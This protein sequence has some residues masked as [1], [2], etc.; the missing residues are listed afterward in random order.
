MNDSTSPPAESLDLDQLEQQIDTLVQRI[1][2]LSNENSTLRKQHQA[3]VIERSK[4][5]EKTETARARVE[6]MISRLKNDGV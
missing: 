6:A 1:D 5:I 4:L 3:L 2:N